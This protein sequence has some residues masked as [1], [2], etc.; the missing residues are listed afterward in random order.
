M[1]VC[2]GS[3][4]HPSVIALLEQHHHEMLS[5]SPPESVHTLDL[6]ALAQKEITFLC[7]WKNGELAGCGALK[8]LDNTH[9]EIK[10]MRTSTDFL[11]QGV[12]KCLLEY[13]FAEAI[14]RGY[15]RLSLETGT[16]DA[17]LPAQELY[18]QLGFHPCQPFAD[19]QE[20]PYSTF[21]S[22]SIS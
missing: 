2:I 6:S 13:I 7:V 8:E 12:A 21:M 3:L 18:Q 1:K 14:N 9:G 22:K 17:F 19:Y 16:M 15:Q 10:S 20:D 5:H 11:R 4:T